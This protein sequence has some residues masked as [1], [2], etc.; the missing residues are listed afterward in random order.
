MPALWFLCRGLLILT[1][2]QNIGHEK[3]Q[4]PPRL[5][6]RLLKDFSSPPTIPSGY[7][8]FTLVRDRSAQAR[9]LPPSHTRYRPTARPHTLHALAAHS[10]RLTQLV[11]SHGPHAHGPSAR[12]L[13][14]DQA[15][16]ALTHMDPRPGPSAQ[17]RPG[18][19]HFTRRARK[20]LLATSSHRAEGSGATGSPWTHGAYPRGPRAL[21]NRQELRALSRLW[22]SGP[23][24]VG[25][26]D[27]ISGRDWR[28]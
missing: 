17:T 3:A 24:L 10:A 14:S 12:P 7:F 1:S 2:D 5:G 22:V 19:H 25:P 9:A 4:D 8:P 26:S 6:P 15:H 28:R 27:S 23:N 18:P 16:T 11:T 13:G 21:H 20:A